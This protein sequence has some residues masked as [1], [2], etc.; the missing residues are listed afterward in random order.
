MEIKITTEGFKEFQKAILRNPEKT[1]SLVSIFLTRS[2]AVLNRQIIRSPWKIGGSGGGSPVAT[3][4]LRD[5]HLREQNPWDI[6]IKATAP[7]AQFIHDGTKNM[8]ARPWLD[9][10]VEQGIPEIE[11][12]DDE[13]V[14]GIVTDLAK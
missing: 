8:Q 3:G 5:T 7:Y 10:A 12:L 2:M 11:K 4:N 6:L 1:K 13:L 14:S 9:F